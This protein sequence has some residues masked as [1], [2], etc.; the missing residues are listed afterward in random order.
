MDKSACEKDLID[1]FCVS[2]GIQVFLDPWIFNSLFSTLL[3]RQ[4]IYDQTCKQYPEKS[5]INIKA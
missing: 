1:G 2:H 4:P 5:S 3:K